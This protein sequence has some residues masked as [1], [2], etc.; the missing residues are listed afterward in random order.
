MARTWG[1]ARAVVGAVFAVVVALFCV[2]GAASAAEPA[3]RVVVIGV[4]G[5][6]WSDIRERATPNLWKLAGQDGAAAMSTRVTTDRTCT[7]DG[8]LTLS[9]GQRAKL[10]NG[11]CALPPAPTRNGTGAIE[12]GW[13]QIVADNAAT[14]YKAEPGMLGGAVH[15]A[16]GCTYAVGAGAVLAAAD[17]QG[18]VDHF[19]ASPAEVPAADWG[20][21]ALT[22]VDV[23]DLFS[24]YIKAGVTSSGSQAPVSDQARSE[25]ATAADAKIGRVL[26]SVPAGTPVLVAGLADSTSTPH[27]HVAIGT[28]SFGDGYLTSS[29]TRRDGLVTLT[30]VPATVLS[31]LG[32]AQPAEAVGAA[33]TSVPSSDTAAQ[34]TE[35]LDDQDAAAQSIRRMSG[36][37]FVVLFAV[38]LLIYAF[39]AVTLR[40]AWGALNRKRIL[41][42]TRVVALT[43][44]SATVATYLANLIP[45]WRSS[46]PAPA[47]VACVVLFTALVTGLS[48]AGPWR[49][50]LVG[51]ALVI[52]GLTAVVL[53]LDAITGS[54]LQINAFMG[55]TGLVGGR[56]YGFGNMA[57]AVFAT[58]SVLTAAWLAEGLLKAG[59]RRAAIGVVIVIGLVAMVVD[60]M[61][62]WGSDFGGVI[63]IM[64]GTAVLTLLLAGWKVSAARLAL[65]AAAGAAL[66]LALAFLDSRR[67][68]PTHLG[69]F[70]AQLVSGDAGDVIA[71]KFGSMLQFW[72]FTIVVVGAL[73]FLFF[74]LARPNSWRAAALDAAFRQT[75]TLR[76]ALFAVLTIALAGMVMNDSGVVIPALV[77]TLAM[78]LVLSVCVRALE[79]D[80]VAVPSR[81][82]EPAPKP[83][84][85]A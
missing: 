72:P 39:A 77:F 23:D 73:L 12:P 78:P 34:K 68:A 38:Q 7:I 33:W 5:L 79:L 57:F 28:A 41:G 32:I 36:A 20:R 59:R 3:G 1:A 84:H 49:R 16:G 43:G 4:P 81:S 9:A 51:P 47:L 44:G 62:G 83:A 24:A 70:W 67:A 56:F 65:V 69:K 64:L 15:T 2:P 18:S 54:G 11:S 29:A 6:Q 45:W 17:R 61:P 74:V 75:E 42:A 22:V 50:S 82:A 58:A 63:A 31:L 14:S 13:P 8:W 48:L 25:A 26:S 37:F 27:L 10:A 85:K 66:V 30:D 55:Y 40:G 19:A 35:V 71:R 60:G 46:H 80:P 76:P 53:G 21:C 52:S